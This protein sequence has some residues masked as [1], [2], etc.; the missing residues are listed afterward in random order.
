[1]DG[2]GGF[3]A[4]SDQNAHCG[5]K[6]EGRIRL[7]GVSLRT[8]SSVAGQEEHR[9]VSRKDPG[10][11][12]P[13]GPATDAGNCDGGEPDSARM[14]RIFSS[15]RAECLCKGRSVCAATAAHDSTQTT[16]AARTSAWTRSS[17]VAECLL[18]RARANL[19]SLGPRAR[20]PISLK[21]PLTGEPDAGNPPVR[22][23]GRGKV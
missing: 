4:A 3:N 11:N 5:C 23:G 20:E 6:P 17:T 1:M 22:F 18:R 7:S 19:L 16:Q 14:V 10:E 15:Q 21:R 13:T 9:Q 12:A 8:R 2:G